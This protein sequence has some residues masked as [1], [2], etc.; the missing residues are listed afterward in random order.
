MDKAPSLTDAEAVFAELASVGQHASTRAYNALLGACAR[1]GAWQEA[2]AR[3][4]DMVAVGVRHGY[5]VI[6]LCDTVIGAV[7][8]VCGEGWG[9]DG[10]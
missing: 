2:R 3:F 8:F 5:W 7:H 10:R 9:A 4:D 6:E 1:G